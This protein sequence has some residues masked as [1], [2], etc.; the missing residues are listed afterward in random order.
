MDSAVPFVVKGFQ[1]LARIF[2]IGEGKSF[3]DSIHCPSV[4]HINGGRFKKIKYQ[5]P[6]DEMNGIVLANEGAQFTGHTLQALL[7]LECRHD[8]SGESV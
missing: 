4:K 2:F 6:V 7:G 8:D 3:S 5:L 1:L